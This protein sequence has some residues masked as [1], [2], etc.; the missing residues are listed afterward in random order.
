LV[1]N[2]TLSY[3]DSIILKNVFEGLE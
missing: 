1:V 3:I 2:E